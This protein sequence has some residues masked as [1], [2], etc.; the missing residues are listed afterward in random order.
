MN[1]GNIKIRGNIIWVH[2]TIDGKFYRES[3]GV[4]ATKS[5]VNIYKKKNHI[6]V[7]SSIIDNKKPKAIK[8]FDL[9]SFGTKVLKLTRNKRSS[10]V[11]DDYVS[12]FKKKILPHFSKFP[13][14]EIK[15]MDIEIWEE[16][17]SH[18]SLARRSRIRNV[19][20]MILRKASAND[21]IPKNPYNDID[22]L[23]DQKEKTEDKVYTPQE[24]KRVLDAADGWY[25]VY[26]GLLF[27]TGARVGEIIGLQWSDIDFEKRVITI[28]RSWTK[29][30]EVFTNRKKNHD[31]NIPMF[32]EVY[33][34]LSEYQKNKR[35]EKWLF[36]LNDD[37]QIPFYDNTSI[38]KELEKIFLKANVE[39]RSMRACRPSFISL[40]IESKISLSWIQATVGHQPNSRVTV[41]KYFKSIRNDDE[42]IAVQA[43]IE[44]RKRI[45]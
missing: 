14:E 33:D 40:M 18:L 13:I 4:E 25:K 3:T 31:R 41:D 5:N 28:Q 43:N 23:I 7:L 21:L 6:Q 17:F 9:K 16:Q 37:D 42:E 12:I 30:G 8:S 15:L 24:I 29:G 19:F 45:R 32:D 38:K 20:R 11:H 2:G 44:L 1:T 10:A 35:H 26:L 22:S 39:Y 34:L 27:Q 36:I